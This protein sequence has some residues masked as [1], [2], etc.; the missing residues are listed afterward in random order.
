MGTANEATRPRR[1]WA[2]KREA[3]GRGARIVFARDGYARASIDAIA[4]EAGV[5][6]RTIYNHFG[7]KETLFTSV[8]T[9]SSAR[10]RDVLVART[11]QCL[12]SPAD[13]EASL[14]AVA[15]AWMATMEEFSEHFALIRVITTEA[16]HFPSQARE[17]W[18]HTGPE[19]ARAELAR[20]FDLL[21]RQRLLAGQDPH[22]MAI[23][24]HLLAFA[25][26]M[27]RSQQGAA[28]LDKA[29][30]S[31]II[32]AGIRTFLRGHLPR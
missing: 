19:A 23:H 28:V 18:Q 20:H 13:L 1:G 25:E 24:F 14:I 7:D 27:E 6:T 21:T 9:E 2:D 26:I 22:R 11:R 31:T 3:I 10:V 5:S 8:V 12:D 15:Q 4:L 32:T 30:I 17:A 16:N 29:E